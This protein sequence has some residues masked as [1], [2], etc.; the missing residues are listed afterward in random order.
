MKQTKVMK[1]IRDNL[2]TDLRKTLV[3]SLRVQIRHK[4]MDNEINE[5]MDQAARITGQLFNSDYLRWN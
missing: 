3:T 5:C 1:Q 2:H 4:V